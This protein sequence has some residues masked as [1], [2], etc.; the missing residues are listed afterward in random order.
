MIVF[1]R[2]STNN[3]AGQAQYL[4]D[5][6]GLPSRVRSGENVRV[7][8]LQHPHRGPNR[9]ITGRSVHNSRIER[10]W[11]DVFQGCTVM[12]YSVLDVNSLHYVFLP[13]LQSSISDGLE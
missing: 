10:L 1:L 3:R 4:I 12:F 7:A 8:M 5:N 9:I 6:Y 2:C 11:R 13:K